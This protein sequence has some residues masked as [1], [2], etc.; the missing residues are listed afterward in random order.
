MYTLLTGQT[1]QGIL[2]SPVTG[3]RGKSALKSFFCPLDIALLEVLSATSDISALPSKTKVF[4]MVS[5]S[6]S[7]S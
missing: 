7:D 1:P 5:I 4:K 6:A 2:M 3:I